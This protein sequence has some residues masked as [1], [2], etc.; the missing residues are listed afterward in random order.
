MPPHEPRLDQALRELLH[1]T[2]VAAL[3]TLADDGA[4]Q[5]SMVPFVPLA[6]AGTAGV[7]IHV[8]NL[9]SH[10]RHLR[11][12][13]RASLLVTGMLAPGDSPL[14]LPRVTLD[15]V[16][17]VL[18]DTDPLLATGRAAYLARFADAAVTTALPDFRFVFIELHAARHVA[19]FGTARSVGRDVLA[20]LL[21]R[22]A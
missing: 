6:G 16:A 9:A 14:A 21:S 22:P 1:H 13:P 11:R 2:P 5:V 18:D 17:R 19:G 3:G 10:S 8:S 4:P 12:D 7:L 15:G 20:R